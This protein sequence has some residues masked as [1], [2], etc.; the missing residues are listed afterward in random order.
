MVFLG[1]LDIEK[2]P[3][4][5]GLCGKPEVL[6]VVVLVET[7]DFSLRLG[8]AKRTAFHKSLE[9]VREHVDREL[10]SLME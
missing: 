1:L 9:F 8:F 2:F 10:L 4:G 7:I 3:L 6:A 5:N